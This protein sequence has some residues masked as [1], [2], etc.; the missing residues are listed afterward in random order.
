MNSSR[1]SAVSQFVRRIFQQDFHSAL[2]GENHQLLE[3]AKRRFDGVF[4]K[5][6]PAD[7]QMLDQIAERN[8][9]G[10][11]Q[12]ALDLTH[13]VDAVRL[14]PVGDVDV[15]V[16][17]GAAPDLVGVHRRM[18]R[19]ELQL[20]IAKPVPQFAD[21]RFVPVVQMLRRAEDFDRRTSP[22]PPRDSARP[23]SNDDCTI[24][25]VDKTLSMKVQQPFAVASAF[26]S[27]APSI[28]CPSTRM[29]AASPLL[30]SEKRRITRAHSVY[31]LTGLGQCGGGPVTKVLLN[32]W[33]AWDIRRQPRVRSA[34]LCNVPLAILSPALRAF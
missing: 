3:R 18:Q 19:M 24:T 16:R 17:P 23:W 9:L 28:H 14:V 7:A 27:A 15:R 13:P 6:L 33:G 5:L 20:G 2:P 4:G 22:R 8:H 21:L 32:P 31:C 1:R 12:R 10:D 34:D 30:R 29:P 11:F 26:L 25:C